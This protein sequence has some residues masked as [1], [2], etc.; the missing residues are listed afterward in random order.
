MIEDYAK[1]VGKYLDSLL[2]NNEN[3][4][5][6]ESLKAHKGIL[7]NFVNE[8]LNDLGSLKAK[9]GYLEQHVTN[10]MNDNSY[11]NHPKVQGYFRS[12]ALVIRKILDKILTKA[13]ID[14]KLFKPEPKAIMFSLQRDVK[15]VID[16]VSKILTPVIPTL[17]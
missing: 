2:D 8:Q 14:N 17:R 15:F 16:Y 5:I 1:Y 7:D 4:E 11:Q 9:L 3:Y 6:K 13:G 10:A 12:I